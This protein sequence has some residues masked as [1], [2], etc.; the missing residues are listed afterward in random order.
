MRPGKPHPSG[1]VLIALGG[2]GLALWLVSRG[3]PS[4]GATHEY[5]ASEATASTRRL[6]VSPI[7]H[8][9][10]K[11]APTFSGT[12]HP[13]GARGETIPASFEVAV[14]SPST[15]A[16]MNLLPLGHEEIARDGLPANAL[17]CSRDGG[18]L[19]CGSCWTDNDCPRGQGCVPNRGTRHFECMTSECEEDAHCFPGS[20]CRAISTGT[21]DLVIRRCV[22]EGIR[23]EGE[24]CD[25]DHVSPSSACREGLR[26]IHQVCTAPCRLDDPRSCPAGHECTD[27]LDGPGCVPDCQKLG[28]PQGQQCKRL[29]T[30]TY[31]CLTSISGTC[32]ET[33]CSEGE[34]CNQAVWRGRGAFWC[35]RLCD[36]LRAGS[37]PQGYVCG[38]GGGGTS[39]CFR[40]CDHTDLDS[41][42]KGWMCATAS[43]DFTLWGCQPALDL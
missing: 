8:P 6:N 23:R 38:H 7:E 39:T 16:T 3:M 29:N 36:P 2:L 10:G 12:P 4:L 35:A 21:S 13:P 43:E 31:Q 33:P 17:R 1:V 25:F 18:T 20:A 26:C 41:C 14:T 11:V 42:G 30:G 34:R 5:P 28:C 22:P 40:A 37:C 24:T 27:S 19:K 9:S 15:E 32:P